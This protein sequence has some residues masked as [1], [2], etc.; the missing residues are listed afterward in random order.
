MKLVSY[1]LATLALGM[2]VT[3]VVVGLLPGGD[4]GAA[5][6]RPNAFKDPE[7]CDVDRAQRRGL[8]VALIGLGVTSGVAALVTYGGSERSSS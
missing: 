7:G 5:L 1:L 2:V 8:P 4:C 6:S 3:G